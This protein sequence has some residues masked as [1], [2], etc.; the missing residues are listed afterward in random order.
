MIKPSFYSTPYDYLYKSRSKYEISADALPSCK[1][2]FNHT[3]F[4]FT[5]STQV[6]T[7]DIYRS[8][9]LP[10]EMCIMRFS[11]IYSIILGMNRFLQRNFH[12]QNVRWI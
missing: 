8:H 9:W 10:M 3:I 7:P 2:K 1:M 12:V 4:G 5:F 6:I 11:F